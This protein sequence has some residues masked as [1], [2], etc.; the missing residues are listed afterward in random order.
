MKYSDGDWT[1]QE[2]K[3]VL[4]EG[5][6]SLIILDVRIDLVLA[7]SLIETSIQTDEDEGFRVVDCLVLY[8]IEDFSN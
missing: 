4:Q 1:S 5:I 3:V 2:V 7:L 8:D 6:G